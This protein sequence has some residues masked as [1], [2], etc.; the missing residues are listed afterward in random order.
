[1]IDY[2]EAIRRESRRFREVLAGVDADSDVPSCP[3]WTA[4][5][6]LWHLTE[7]QM[8]WGLIVEHGFDGPEPAQ[9]LKSPRPDSYEEL[10]QLFDAESARLSDALAHRSPADTCWS[11]DPKGGTVEWV[12]RRQAHEAQIHRLDA[13]LTAGRTTPLG[14]ELAAD[15]VDEMLGVFIADIPEWGRFA[16][17]GTAGVI[18]ATDTDSTW[19]FAYGRFS[20]VSPGSG[21]NYD[22]DAVDLVESVPLSPTVRISGTASAIDAWLWGRGDVGGLTVEGDGELA[23]RLRAI[24]VEATQ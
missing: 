20:G 22:L 24:A 15:G 17:D 6:L 4:A 1:M 23:V 18:E 5:D 21:T 11:W 14:A 19:A 3:G 10:L 2:L 7:V 8:F 9:E 16:P 12:R 13:E